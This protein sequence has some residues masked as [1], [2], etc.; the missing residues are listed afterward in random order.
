MDRESL[1]AAGDS[2]LSE[3]R[4][5]TRDESQFG[6][7]NRFSGWAIVARIFDL[8]G[9][10]IASVTIRQGALRPSAND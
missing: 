6:S 3:M 1:R 7:R 9:H 5:Q 8:S 4:T 10:H 2:E